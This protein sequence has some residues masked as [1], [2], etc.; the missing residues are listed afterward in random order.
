M[1]VGNMTSLGRTRNMRIGIPHRLSNTLI[2][3]STIMGIVLAIVGGAQAQSSAEGQALFGSK[4]YS[5]HNIGSGDKQ[6]PDLK[7]VTTRRTKEWLH[8][9]I[10]TPAAVNSKGDPIATQLFKKFSPTV[11][12]DQAL[13]P[14]QIDSILMMIEELTNKNQVFVP[15]GAKL[16]RTIVP[17]D[18]NGG[19][20]F[21]TGRARLQNGG[22][23]CISC[24]SIKGVGMFGGGTLGPDLTG[25]SIK[26]RDP[27]LISI[28]QNPN[29]PTM[30]TVFA[31]HRL[32]DEE[33]VQLFALFQDAKLR[34]PV[35]P[36]QAGITTLDP[37]FFVIGVASM[38]VALALL[39]LAWRNRLRGVR[40]ELVGRTK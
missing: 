13:T 25:A 27:E 35:P 20:Q 39:N 28:L 6:G 4:C 12:P 21:F 29:F 33:I 5:C 23:A 30:S 8:E 31:T 22:T 7:G 9:F 10:N 2:R 37:R 14:Q 1:R 38:L 18:V 24:H 34:N 11:M 3:I 17:S 19:W 36:P 32:N 40:E 26:Y 16:S 15:A